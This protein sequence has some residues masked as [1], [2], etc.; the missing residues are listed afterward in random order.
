MK[1]I[2]EDNEMI[3]IFNYKITKRASEIIKNY[4]EIDIKTLSEERVDEIIQDMNHGVIDGYKTIK[5]HVDGSNEFVW[6]EDDMRTICYICD[7]TGIIGDIGFYEITELNIYVTEDTNDGQYYPAGDIGDTSCFIDFLGED[8]AFNKNVRNLVWLD[9]ENIFY[10]ALEDILNQINDNKENDDY[11]SLEVLNRWSCTLEEA[12]KSDNY[13]KD[14]EFKEIGCFA[15]E[16]IYKIDDRL[17]YLTD[18]SYTFNTEH[19]YYLK[20]VSDKCYREFG[21]NKPEN[22]CYFINK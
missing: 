12:L 2:M 13:Y 3:N 11:I 16:T 19:H 20:E 4:Y 9:C 15:G 18:D 6:T 22:K 1:A 5:L 8:K 7:R 10:K 17:Y 14:S 21:L